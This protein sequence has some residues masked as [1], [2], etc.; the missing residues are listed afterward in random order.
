MNAMPMQRPQNRP[1][2]P[3]RITK[4][5]GDLQAELAI[6]KPG[7]VAL[8]PDYLRAAIQALRWVLGDPEARR[9]PL[10]DT[11]L[12]R[13]PTLNEIAVE[14]RVAD[15]V[16]HGRQ[17]RPHERMLSREVVAYEHHLWWAYTGR[18]APLDEDDE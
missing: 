12:G 6:A 7:D 10:T 3:E 13:A 5:I 16:L 2:S 4:M 9:A 17:P 14:H 1:P 11:V 15:D 8:G 18:G